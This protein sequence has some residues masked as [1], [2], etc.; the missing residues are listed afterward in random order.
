MSGGDV[1]AHQ[2]GQGVRLE[3]L[4]A[5]ARRFVVAVSAH[6]DD[7]A[8]FIDGNHQGER[9][10]AGHIVALRGHIGGVGSRR[11]RNRS[12]RS[13]LLEC[14]IDGV[15]GQRHTGLHVDLRGGDVLTHQRVKHGGILDQGSAQTR[16][17]AVRGHAHGDDLAVRVHRDL[18]GERLEAGH[19]IGRNVGGLRLLSGSRF[20]LLRRR[21]RL[22]NN[23][24][25]GGSSLPERVVDGR[26]GQRHAGL[27]IDLGGGDVLTDQHG[28]RLLRQQ[29]SAKARGLVVLVHGHRGDLAIL[30]RNVHGELVKALDGV[31]IGRHLRPRLTKRVVDGVAG[32][33]RTGLHVDAGGGDVLTHQRVKHG[34]VGDQV[35]AEARRFVV[36]RYGH[37]DDLAIL[38]H[39]DFHLEGL[40]TGHVVRS[41]RHDGLGGLTRSSGCSC[42]HG[43]L[44]ARVR[45][46]AQRALRVGQHVRNGVHK[47]GRGDR[48]AAQGVH[49]VA[50]RVGISRNR[51][52]LVLEL[53][54][55]HAA[56]QTRGL[57]QRADIHLR[58]ITL[59]A[60]AEGDR[61][62]SAV[63][64]R[65]GGQR[66]A[67]NLAVDLADKE[68]VKDAVLG[69]SFIFN[70][71]V[72]AAR[73]HR[74]QRFHLGCEL[75]RLDR[76]L[77]HFVGDG[78]SHGGDKR[79]GEQTNR[80][81]DDITHSS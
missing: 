75:L 57:L 65:R 69:D 39:R 68:L 16:R 46:D 22:L 40:K 33:R 60:H 18:H 8:A 29:I 38:V 62:L 80:Q 25:I 51:D 11:I 17:L 10:E 63:A 64:L 77:R 34:G 53:A 32:Q 61:D 14:V 37:R 26:A 59:R 52:E 67:L 49:V 45:L 56:A 47:R 71:L 2:H 9:L 20:L 44:V 79:K 13:S 27:R 42:Q 21:S 24:A 66:V 6:G 73:K 43:V 36:L 50:E 55:A 70:L 31:R 30:H 72:V 4:T 7:L 78:Q 35:R 19:F 74:I 76:P 81:L 12:C 28:E 58:H 41:G 1:L 23:E 54:L 3:D 15:A 48:R 5:D